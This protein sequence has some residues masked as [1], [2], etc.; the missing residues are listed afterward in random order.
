M[1]KTRQ[2]FIVD[3][4]SLLSSPTHYFTVESSLASFLDLVKRHRQFDVIERWSSPRTDVVQRKV[5][6]NRDE[7]E[8]GVPGVW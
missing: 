7:V 3:F 1:V 5:R 2:V 8:V 6:R 4:F